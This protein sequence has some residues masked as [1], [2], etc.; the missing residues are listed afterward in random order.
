LVVAPLAELARAVARGGRSALATRGAR[1]RAEHALR[2][3]RLG[4][5]AADAAT[6]RIVGGAVLPAH[7][8]D[9]VVAQPAVLVA[10]RAV[11]LELGRALERLPRA[12][13]VRGLGVDDRVDAAEGAAVDGP[14]R[15][16]LPADRPD[17][18][19]ARAA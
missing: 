11:L 15:A 3:R 7:G 4:G 13:A 9:A 1:H 10:E 17:A 6:D 14:R 5:R 2:A 18:V 8:A 16:D 12:S 19:V